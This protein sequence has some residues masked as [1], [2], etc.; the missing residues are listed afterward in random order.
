ALGRNYRLAAG[1]LGDARATLEM[2]LQNLDRSSA[3][4]RAGWVREAQGIY[5][6]WRRE[7]APLL[8]SDAVPI[9]P[10][11]ICAE[12]TRAVPQDAIVVVDTGHGGMWMGG[13][14]D[15]TAPSQDY[16]R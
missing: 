4:A 16:I 3:A 15:L 8:S 1:V 10:E 14:F 7:Y 12:L 5:E 6:D 11:R 2:M 13:M 9:R